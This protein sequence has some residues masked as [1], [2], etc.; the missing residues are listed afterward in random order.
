MVYKEFKTTSLGLFLKQHFFPI[1]F[2]LSLAVEV[3]YI[4]LTRKLETM[5]SIIIY[6]EYSEWAHFLEPKV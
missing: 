3:V 2:S 6:F 4:P 1:F 5:V